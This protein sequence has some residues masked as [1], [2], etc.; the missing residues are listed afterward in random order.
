MHVDNE[1]RDDA[2]VT[3]SI[4][5]NNYF[6]NLKIVKYDINKIVYQNLLYLM[7]PSKAFTY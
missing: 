2:I 7:N 5:E 4:I 6:E 3:V 1:I